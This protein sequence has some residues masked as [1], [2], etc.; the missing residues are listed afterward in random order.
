MPELLGDDR[1]EPFVHLV[2]LTD[3]S[4]LIGWGGFFFGGPGDRQQ[5]VDDDDL[6][7]PGRAEG[8]TIG[9][10]SPP[11]GRARVE[12]LDRSGAVV[13]AAETAGANHVWV[14]GL[15]PDTE[16]RYRIEVDGTRWA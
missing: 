14:H 1:F 13:A 10:S 12:V 8:G 6:T 15:E 3:R 7:G 4:A 16:Y 9:A 2:D 11:Y 5:V